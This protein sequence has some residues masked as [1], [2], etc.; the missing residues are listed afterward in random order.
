MFPW[1][2]FDLVENIV[3]ASANDPETADRDV[4]LKIRAYEA[5]KS[6]ALGR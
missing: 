3:C 5:G 1:L 4:K 6:L 2:G